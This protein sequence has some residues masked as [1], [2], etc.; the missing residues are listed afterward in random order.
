MGRSPRAPGWF[1]IYCHRA[2]DV[3]TP[4][5]SEWETAMKKR[6]LLK[7]GLVA[8]LGLALIVAYLIMRA[9]IL[10]WRGI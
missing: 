5:R 1:T 4:V 10:L 6:L 2:R 9:V 3:Q 7:V 8:L